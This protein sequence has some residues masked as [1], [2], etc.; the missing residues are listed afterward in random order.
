MKKVREIK[1]TKEVKY[2][3]DSNTVLKLRNGCYVNG[4]KVPRNNDIV[5]PFLPSNVGLI[6]YE[7][8][9]SY[10]SDRMQD[11]SLQEVRS[12]KFDF[13]KFL[14]IFVN[15]TIASVGETDDLERCLDL[16][17]KME[18]LSG[19]Y[20]YHRNTV[21]TCRGDKVI[22]QVFQPL[23]EEFGPM[24]RAALGEEGVKMMHKVIE[25][26]D[27]YTLSLCKGEG[28]K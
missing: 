17:H 21:W 2:L 6:R 5:E 10:H 24:I 28:F 12:I 22:K 18:L 1:V 4:E 16:L 11:I 20:Y 26:R 27:F 9:V 25:L 23:D 14:R 13:C 15:D 7:L 8:V 3:L 19:D